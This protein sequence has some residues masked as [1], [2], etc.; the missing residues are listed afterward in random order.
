MEEEAAKLKEL[1]TETEKTMGLS[2][3]GAPA[4]AG[5]NSQHSPDFSE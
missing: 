5:N 1:Q 3:N 2:P 4:A